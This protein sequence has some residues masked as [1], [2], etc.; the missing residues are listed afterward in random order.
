MTILPH[1][2]WLKRLSPPAYEILEERDCFVTMRDGVRLA[3]DI[4]R[5]KSAGRFPGLVSVSAYGKHVQKMM[6]RTLPLSPQRGNGG[7]EAGDTA[8]WVKRGYVHIIVDVRGSGASEGVYDY[9]GEEE[10]KDGCEIIEWAASQP[11]CSGKVGML[12]MS[13]FGVMQWLVAMHR[14]AHLT[15]I[16]PYEAFIDRYRHSFYHGGILNVGFFHQWWGHVSVPPMRPLCKRYLTANE[17]EE[18]RRTLLASREVA[19]S[20]FLDVA[21]HYPEK[22]PILFDLLMQPYDSAYAQERS[23]IRRLHEIEI[24]CFLA[25]R[26]SGWAIHLPGVLAG[27]EG[28]SHNPNKKLFLMESPSMHGPLRPWRDHQD[29]LMR[30][31]DHWLKGNDTGMMDESPVTYLVKGS[32][33]W[34]TADDW[35]IPQT[36]WTNF[37][38]HADGLIS[39][40]APDSDEPSRHFSNDPFLAPGSNTPGLSYSTLPL[41]RDMVLVG[42]IG[43]HFHASIDHTDATWIVTVR[44][45]ATDGKSTIITKGWLRASHRELDSQRSKP[46]KPFHPHD[47]AIPVIP[48]EVTQYSIDIKEVGMRIAKGHRLSLDIRGQD[49]PAEDPIWYHLCNGTVTRHTVHHAKAYASYL[50]LPIQP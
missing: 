50:V 12:G 47:R 30:W 19:D 6:E 41:E 46:S 33:E 20:P 36:T 27:W 48:G 40:R 28:L 16:A 3:C 32:N 45:E 43:L 44:D 1:S 24:P 34:R 26:W 22:N 25:A 5:P 2:D 17:I 21:L 35:P 38:L 14:P 31:Y 15:A 9:L 49:T 39:E 37:Y 13:Y 10:Q 8:Y 4:F 23:A 42:A 18:R 7:Q 11:W 29:I